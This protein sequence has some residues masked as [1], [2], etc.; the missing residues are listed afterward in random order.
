[1][2]RFGDCIRVLLLSEKF[3]VMRMKDRPNCTSFLKGWRQ[4]RRSLSHSSSR[5]SSIKSPDRDTCIIMKIRPITRSE[6][7]KLCERTFVNKSYFLR[8][9]LHF[10]SRLSHYSLNKPQDTLST[11]NGILKCAS[12]LWMKPEVIH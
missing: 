10:T 1:M 9:N 8:L 6:T 11:V 7:W 12:W 2:F 4:I 3:P 5:T